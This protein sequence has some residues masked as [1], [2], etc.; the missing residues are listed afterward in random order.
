MGS[1]LSFPILCLANLGLYLE[2]I[3][4]DKRPLSEKLA[5]VLVN[6]DDMLYVAPE[7][8]WERHVQTGRKVGLE[9]T[10]GKAYK[11]KVFANANSTC[12]H[13]DLDIE[14]STPW[15]IDFL[16]TGLLFGQNKVLQKDTGVDAEGQHHR[17]PVINQLLKGALPGKERS[18]LRTTSADTGRRSKRSALVAISSLIPHWVVWALSPHPIGNGR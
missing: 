4:D 9:M 11:H 13:Y 10:P 5:G 12:F 7:S 1:P 15:Q 17:V 14:G 16:N 2:V 18:L 6:G 8:L 3:K